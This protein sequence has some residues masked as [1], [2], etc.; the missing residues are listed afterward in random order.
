M[1]GTLKVKKYEFSAYMA[2]IFMKYA[3]PQQLI[4]SFTNYR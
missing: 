2:T 3:R 4:N 1:S